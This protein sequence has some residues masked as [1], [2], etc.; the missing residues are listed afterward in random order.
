MI[1][2]DSMIIANSMTGADNITVSAWLLNNLPE[3]KRHIDNLA[4]QVQ[5]A[6]G[7]ER[8]KSEAKNE[9]LENEEFH[10]NPVGST[11]SST[12]TPLENRL[13]KV[14]RGDGTDIGPFIWEAHR[15][16]F[17]VL[18]CAVKDKNPA[19]KN[20]RRWQTE[21]QSGEQVVE[22]FQRHSG[23]YAVLCG[24]VSGNLVVID[25][26]TSECFNQLRQEVAERVGETW[27]VKSDRGGHIYLQTPSPAK[28]TKNSADLDVKGEGG[29]VIGAGSLHPSGQV[30]SVVEPTH[31]VA[32]VPR[33]PSI[34]FEFLE[35]AERRIQRQK[36][37]K[38]AWRLFHETKKKEAQYPSPSEFDQAFIQ[39]CVNVGIAEDI[40]RYVLSSS[41]EPTSYQRRRKQQGL[42]QA[43]DFFATSYA[44]AL[45]KEDSEDFKAHRKE[46]EAMRRWVLNQTW[47]G[48]TG[49]TDR[50]VLL[51]HIWRFQV[52]LSEDFH[53]SARD[54]AEL[55]ELSHQTFA[56]A[57]YRLIEQGYLV[58][59]RPP[60]VDLAAEYHLVKYQFV[61][62]TLPHNINIG[63]APLT[64]SSAAL[65]SQ[66]GSNITSIDT[67]GVFER[68]GLGKSARII[69]EFLLEHEATFKE[70]IQ[71]TGKVRSTVDKYLKI[72]AMHGLVLHDG[73]FYT[74]TSDIDFYALGQKLN[75][76]GLSAARKERHQRDR[77][78]HNAFFSSRIQ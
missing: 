36:A 53:L 30:Y 69:W 33:L 60:V 32:R 77:L 20:W 43:D 42:R 64:N 7:R 12:D 13:G 51:A 56:R 37:W 72:L 38:K 3:L 57:T 62:E 1:I 74:A 18:P 76:L 2:V 63:S 49:A 73:R 41:K 39:A 6:S 22:L 9:A 44:K 31:R 15:M 71:G 17:N 10:R 5:E 26:D 8:E 14:D 70:T 16:G 34:T 50:A 23:N 65:S 54:G 52:S 25:C 67:C 46:A 47:R 45:K 35:S 40:I 27:V 11:V 66:T 4:Y 28:T 55:A 59:T 61:P 19:H 58:T 21:R 29:Y 68:K 48:R 78:N 24:S 75:T